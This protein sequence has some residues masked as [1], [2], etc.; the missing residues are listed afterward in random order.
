ME[1]VTEKRID[2]AIEGAI[3][4]VSE[5]FIND[6]QENK[7][8]FNAFINELS[9]NEYPSYSSRLASEL[10]T[11]K[12]ARDHSVE[13]MRSVLKELLCDQSTVSKI[14]NKKI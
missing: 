2:R 8:S 5:N 12:T 13:I 14:E 4:N 11:Y 6:Y 7:K 3:L 9:N 1:K 10:S